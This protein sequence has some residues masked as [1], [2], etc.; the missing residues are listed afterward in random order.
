MRRLS[1]SCAAI[2]FAVLSAL[3]SQL[4]A[5]DFVLTIGGGYS[6]LGNQ[7]SIERNAK[8]FAE[9]IAERLPDAKHDILF[10]DGKSE[11]RDVQ[12]RVNDASVPRVWK[13][14]SQVFQQEKNWGMRYRTHQI[15][16][17]S[18]A[19]TQENVIKWFDDASQV[20]KAG[21]R[22]LI[23]ATVHGGSAA[24]KEAPENTLMYLWNS[25]RL[26]V[27]EFKSY[28][29]RFRPGVQ[30][31]LVMAQCHG[32][33]FA[34]AALDAGGLAAGATPERCGFFATLFDRPASGCTPDV[35]GDNEHEYSSYFWAALRGRDR[36]GMKIQPVDYNGDGETSL[37]EAHT[38]A[39][40]HAQSIDIPLRTSAAYL[41]RIAPSGPSSLVGPYSIHMPFE[42]LREAAD[43][44]Q[45]A[46][47]ESLSAQLQIMDVDRGR[48]VMEIAARAADERARNDER[49]KDKATTYQSLCQ[50]IRVS[51]VTRWPELAN[52]WNAQVSALVG[53]EGDS[54]VAAI[55]SHAAYGE[56]RSLQAERKRLTDARW[57]HD[58]RYAKS[59]RLL[60]V[61]EDVAIAGNLRTSGPSEDWRRYARLVTLE[62]QSLLPTTQ[63]TNL[64]PGDI[65]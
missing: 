59:Q 32:G 19:A 3:P 27:K 18:G 16:G 63:A 53:E 13:L 7:V 56:L 55:E 45:L 21:D 11:G 38:Y 49:L 42:K 41:R 1:L 52:P 6:P 4:S 20:A 5:R 64:L 12:Y 58:R 44:G 34:D 9:L 29:D 2:A 35:E 25:Q 37:A 39:I 43:A 60:R 40:I 61:L 28:L 31:V 54:I 8:F 22:V 14:L 10:S 36:E 26:S 46:A 57:E 62:N 33:G 50:Q 24:D 23:Y 51:L 48:E 30:V 65:R 15:A 47:M 17:V